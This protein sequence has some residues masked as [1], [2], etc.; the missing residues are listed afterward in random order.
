MNTQITA[1]CPI[2][3]AAINRNRKMGTVSPP[4]FRKKDAATSDK[5]IIYPMEP[6]NISFLRPNLSIRNTPKSVKIRL[7]TPMPILLN[8]AVLAANPAASKIRGA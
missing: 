3:C 7:T 6:M 8:N 4:Q 5:E 1:P 2:A